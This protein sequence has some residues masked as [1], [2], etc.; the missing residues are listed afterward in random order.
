MTTLLS[1]LRYLS[2]GI[3][4]TVKVMQGLDALGY[5]EHIDYDLVESTNP[6][7]QKAIVR[8]N[9]FRDHRQVSCWPASVQR[10]ATV[11]PAGRT[12]QSLYSCSIRLVLN[13]IALFSHTL[14]K[15]GCLL[16]LYS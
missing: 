16:S 1:S 3:L 4:L 8:V 12:M 9:I 14:C 10:E 2:D 15:H 5:S 13:Q 7:F 11:H 6:A